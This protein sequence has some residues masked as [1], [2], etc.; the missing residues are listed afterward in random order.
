MASVT[1]TTKSDPFDRLNEAGV[2]QC[3]LREQLRIIEDFAHAMVMEDRPRDQASANTLFSLTS[4]ALIV[5]DHA[6]ADLHR[7]EDDLHQA[8]V[9]ELVRSGMLHVEGRA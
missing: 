9:P 2:K 3:L 1:D 6:D 7:A 5:L 8:G 4:I